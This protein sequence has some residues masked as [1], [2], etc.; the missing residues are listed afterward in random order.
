M[1]APASSPTL[2]KVLAGDLCSGCGLCA[3]ISGGALEIAE[4]ERGYNRPREVRPVSAETDRLIAHCCPGSAV[5]GWR[6]SPETD[7]FWGPCR[8]VL[9]GHA[10]DP[11]LR[12]AGSSG[13]MLSALLIHALESGL[14]DA[15]VQIATDPADPSR[16]KVRRSTKAAEIAGS[17]GSRYAPSSPLEQVGALLEEERTRFAFVGKPCDVSALRRLGE[18]D[19]RVAERFPI[20]L[21][22][23]CGGIPSTAGTQ[24]I[25]DDLGVDRADLAHFKYRGDGWPGEVVA[26][27][28]DGSA[29][30]MSYPD[31]WGGRLS[32]RM[33]FRCKICPDAIGGVA[34][35]ACAD[36]WFGDEKGYP[37]FE[38]M[39]GR[40]LAIARSDAGSALLASAQAAGRI[41][42]EPS[43]LEDVGRMQPY[44]AQRKR[45]ILAR[46]AAL[47]ATFQPRPDY[48]GV[49]V[50]AAA[51]RA[52]LG[53]SLRNFLGTLR[54]VVLNRR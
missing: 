48:S 52:G 20:L 41:A 30:R 19:P 51:R 11:D 12:F 35:I 47:V 1:N 26:T 44:Q 15:V 50:P 10:T 13:G 46:T 42:L 4:N 23:F 27:R 25:L 14:V 54:R 7:P 39:D 32:P 40:S 8:Q 6:E 53:E 17:A 21:S 16:N 31:S 45:L 24:Q 3:G 5:A 33:Q 28:H 9:T 18:V 37:L 38:E 49:R 43:S 22:F 2:R 36:A 29:E 34:D